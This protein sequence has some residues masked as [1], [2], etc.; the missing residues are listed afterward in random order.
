[1]ALDKCLCETCHQ[2]AFLFFV[3]AFE[4]LTPVISISFTCL[5]KTDVIN[6]SRLD[7]LHDQEVGS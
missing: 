3:R 7:A 5:T 6:E 2:S 1:M 4:P